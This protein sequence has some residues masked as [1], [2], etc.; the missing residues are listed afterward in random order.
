MLIS[1]AIQTDITRRLLKK[2]HSVWKKFQ[3]FGISSGGNRSCRSV[4][5]EGSRC[6][7]KEKKEKWQTLQN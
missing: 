5:T 7:K 6:W 1:S 3:N 4:V 2:N